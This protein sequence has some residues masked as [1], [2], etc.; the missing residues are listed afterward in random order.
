[1]RREMMILPRFL[2]SFLVHWLVRIPYI[3]FTRGRKATRRGFGSVLITLGR[4]VTESRFRF[5][6][7]VVSR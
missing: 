7:F 4:E 3:F 1:M 6:F 5:R 2:K